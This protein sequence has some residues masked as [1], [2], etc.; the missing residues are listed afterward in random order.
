MSRIR[1]PGLSTVGNR[2]KDAKQLAT[3]LMDRLSDSEFREF[4][5]LLENEDTEDLTEAVREIN[6][7]RHP[8]DYTEA[9]D[10]LKDAFRNIR[11]ED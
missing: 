11:L 2:M 9:S 5:E 8:E 3:L 10:P 1:E 7:S 6:K 4:A